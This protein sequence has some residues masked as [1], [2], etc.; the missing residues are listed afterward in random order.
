MENAWEARTEKIRRFFDKT[1]ETGTWTGIVLSRM[2]RDAMPS[3]IRKSMERFHQHFDDRRHDRRLKVKK[4][5]TGFSGG[6]VF[7]DIHLINISRGGMYI[8]VDSPYEVGPEAA[9][10]LSGKDLGPIM[11]VKGRVMRTA[12]GGLAIQFL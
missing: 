1:R 6:K 9:F 10:N 5:I 11:R 3:P 7:K 12:E 8:E 4:T 2:L